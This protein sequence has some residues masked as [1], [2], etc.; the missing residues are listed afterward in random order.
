VGKGCGPRYAGKRRKEGIV[1]DFSPE[2]EA[3]FDSHAF[4][5]VGPLFPCDVPG[6]RRSFV[7]K[8]RVAGLWRRRCAK[9]RDDE[10]AE[11]EEL[12]ESWWGRQ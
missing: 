1:E 2:A 12:H 9:H 6:C 7:V 3:Y 5:T 11:V 4:V 8:Y 10:E